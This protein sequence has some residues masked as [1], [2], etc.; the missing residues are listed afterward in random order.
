MAT[1]PS[2]SVLS[3]E[4]EKLKAREV[5]TSHIVQVSKR[6]MIIIPC[7][8]MDVCL[9]ARLSLGGFVIQPLEADRIVIKCVV[10]ECKR[11]VNR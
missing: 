6:V 2:V 10:M 7:L 1:P 4:M 9:L 8:V 3:V 11:A 5:Y